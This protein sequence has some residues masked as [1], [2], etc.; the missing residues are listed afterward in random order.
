MTAL[1]AKCY[2]V[3][4]CKDNSNDLATEKGVWSWIQIARAPHTSLPLRK[5]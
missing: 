2:P 1:D 4:T 5:P 3:C